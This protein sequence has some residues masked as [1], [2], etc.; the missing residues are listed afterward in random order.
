V[1]GLE[2]RTANPF[3]FDQGR[4][5][6]TRRRLPEARLDRELIAS[7]RLCE[8]DSLLERFERVLRAAA[9]DEQA[10]KRDGNARRLTNGLSPRKSGA[11]VSKQALGCSMA[12][13]R[14]KFRRTPRTRE[15]FG[16][17]W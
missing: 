3:G 9:L 12:A 8:P 15:E 13:A 1:W 16:Y 14:D 5:R 2:Y 4:I 7:R 17:L 6:D 10:R 11:D